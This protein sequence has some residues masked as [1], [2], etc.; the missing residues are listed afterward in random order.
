[1]AT[2]KE[3]FDEALRRQRSPA[4]DPEPVETFKMLQKLA[5]EGYAPACTK[6]AVYLQ[7]HKTEQALKYLETAVDQNDPSGLSLMGY[8]TY[9]G[10]NGLTKDYKKA[11]G[12]YTR[13]AE[14]GDVDAIL[15]LGQMYQDGEGCDQD[16][17][18]AAYWF[19]KL[20]DLSNPD[21]EQDADA[22]FHLGMLYATGKL[23]KSS[24]AKVEGIV[25][26]REA[27]RLGHS[28]ASEVL[29]MLNMD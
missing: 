13:A 8:W 2:Q 5:N 25:L 11:F 19:R 14:L 6:M 28:G 22:C 9:M 29:T 26:L 1:M 18:K 21:E 16:Y 12:F 24:R 27:R 10:K 15:N 17:D 3:R 4:G 23:G 7:V 20:A